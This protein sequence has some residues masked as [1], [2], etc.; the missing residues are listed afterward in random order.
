MKRYI[1]VIFFIISCNILVAQ[2]I[3]EFSTDTAEFITQ[4]ARFMSGMEGENEYHV[5]RFISI[6]KHDSI[7]Y[8]EKLQIIGVSNQMLNRRANPSPHFINFTELYLLNLDPAYKSK[9][10]DKWFSSYNSLLTTSGVSFNEIQRAQSFALAILKDSV[11]YD[12]AGV[13][14]KA[15][16]D[17]FEFDQVKNLPVVRFR[18]TELTCISNH[19]TLKILE[20]SGYYDLVNL[21]WTGYKGRVTWER[22]GLDPEQVYANLGNYSVEIN[23]AQYKADSVQFFYKKYFDYSLEGYLQDRALPISNPST[24]TFPKFFSYQNL[25]D[26]PDLFPGI[27]FIGGLSMQ[28]AK[29]VGTGTLQSPARLFITQEDT[30]RMLIRSQNIVVRENGM[31]STSCQMTLYMDSDSIYHPDLDFLYLEQGDEIRLSKRDVYT[32][33]VPYTDSYHNMNMNFEEFL[34]K[35][36]SRVISFQPSIGRAIGTATFES[37]RFFN[38]RVFSELQGRDYAHPLVSLWNFSRSL[39]GWREFPLTAYSG[40]IGKPDYQVRHQMMKL[41]RLGFIYYDDKK[42]MITLKDKLFYFIE[43]SVGRTDYDVIMFESNVRAPNEN[44]T[45]N[46]ENYDLTINGIPNIFL[47]DSQNVVLYPS[48]NR[49]VMKKNKNFQF[50]GNVQA[51]LFSLFGDNFFFQ[52]DSF[53][54]NLQDVDSLRVQVMIQDKNSGTRDIINIENLIQNLTGEILIDDP[55]NKSGLENHPEYP[56]FKSTENSYVYFDDP[57]IQGG[58]YGRDEIY[59]ELEPFEIDSLDNFAREGM[60]LTGVFNS[61][62]LIPPLEQVLTLREDNSLGFAFDTPDIGLPVYNGQGTFYN[63]LEMSSSGLRGAGRLDYLTSSTWS[64]DFIFHPDSLLSESREFIV[65]KQIEETEFPEVNSRNNSIKWLTEQEEFRINMTDIPFT[66]FTDTLLLKGDLVLEPEGLSGSGT[67]DLVT[68]AVV[69]DKFRFGSES[70]MADTA[71]FRLNSPVSDKLAINTSNVRANVDLTTRMGQFYANEDYTQVEFPDIQYSSNLDFFEWNFDLQTVQMGLNE[72]VE[73]ATDSSADGLSG[74]RYYS[75]LPSQDSLNFVSP[76]AI[77]DYRKGQLNATEV[78]YIQIADARIYPGDGRLTVE[79]NAVIKQLTD[80]AIVTDYQTEYY[81]LYNAAVSIISRNDYTASADYDYLGLSGEPQTIH[82]N[83]IMVDDSIQTVGEGVINASQDFRLS[84]FFL[85]QGEVFL[86]SQDPD[87]RFKGGARL[88]HDCEMGRQWLKFEARIDPSNVLIPIS[89]APV[90]ID[91]APTYAGIMITRDST[92]IYSTFLS[93]RYDYFDRLIAT[94]N[95]FLR[96]NTDTDAYEIAAIEKLENPGVPGNYLKFDRSDCIVE[97][98]GKLNLQLNYGQIEINN[99]GEAE[100]NISANHFKTHLLMTLDFMFSEE[101][102]I[103]FANDLDSIPGLKPIQL[104]EPFYRQSMRELVGMD[105]ADRMEADLGLFAE[106]RIIPPELKKTLVMTDVNL[107]WSQYTRSYR[108]EGEIGIVRLGER[109]IN[110]NVNVIMELTK[111]AS[112][113]LLDIYFV[114]DDNTWYYFGYSPG[115]LQVVSSNRMFNSI[116]F[117]LKAKDR[118]MRTRMGETGYIYSLAPERRLQLFLRRYN[119][120]TEQES[121][122]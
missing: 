30:L 16:N 63:E 74:P 94:A 90:Q 83:R 11:M 46:L 70:I 33:G 85:Y 93:K 41:S 15:S 47:S 14:W 53:K 2:Q 26:I 73:I 23:R 22:A 78:P 25:Y 116:I 39:N 72:E 58:V 42:D 104:T 92:H 112:G 52:Y 29:L 12:L 100:H 84:P 91:M 102:L 36:G 43:A 57:S 101:A 103:L 3:R 35:R 8:E 71:D 96:Y 10:L 86:E 120:A 111:R 54:I 61:S 122:Q 69:S 99:V 6:W 115:S 32:S 34:W 38:Y 45:L 18:E 87:L 121:L 97:G 113:D 59:F 98:E 117:E 110:R 60:G 88:V 49:V 106:Y 4:Y 37:N 82:F 81:R 55:E 107:E 5:N 21:L 118:K 13:F 64:D 77:Y 66:V 119:A 114:L 95:G 51:G 1:S 65:K 80:A 56:I 9:K 44:A 105:A 79:K 48:D 109:M 89:V 75:L 50:N 76:L 40:N 108:Y 17:E 28:G 19:D 68:S 31:S 27:E 7:P 24:A 20:A 62:G 67:M